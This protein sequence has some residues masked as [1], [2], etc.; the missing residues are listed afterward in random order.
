MRDQ[1]INQ[2]YSIGHQTLDARRARFLENNIKV[3]ES[4][5]SKL[6]ARDSVT[7][8]Y[9]PVL[10]LEK[11]SETLRCHSASIREHNKDEIM[12]NH[13]STLNHLNGRYLSINCYLYVKLMLWNSV[14]CTGR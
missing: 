13:R 6:H 1:S 8:D 7:R 2:I 14:S 5:R 9:D 4:F 10:Q 12:G 3:E 11:R